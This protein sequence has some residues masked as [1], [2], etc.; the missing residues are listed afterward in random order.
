MSGEQKTFTVSEVAQHNEAHDIWV[1]IHGK[2]YDVTQFI[3]DVRLFVVQLFSILVGRKCCWSTQVSNPDQIMAGKDSTDAFE[4][5]GHS[6]GAR[7]LLE[8]FYVGNL[9]MCRVF[10]SA[11]LEPKDRESPRFQD[12]QFASATGRDP[13]AQSRATRSAPLPRVS[14]L[15]LLYKALE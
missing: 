9:V 1:A 7:N 8:G 11:S 15:V 4:D 13:T 2:V 3:Y 10:D 6:S 12:T 5:I 14:P